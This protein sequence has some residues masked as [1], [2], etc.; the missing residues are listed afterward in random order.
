MGEV[1][2]L[3]GAWHKPRLVPCSWPAPCCQRFDSQ[4]IFNS[5]SHPPRPVICH[6]PSASPRLGRKK[7]LSWPPRLLLP[8]S[9]KRPVFRSL[10]TLPHHTSPPWFPPSEK[11]NFLRCGLGAARGGARAL[12]RGRG[13]R[14]SGGPGQE[15]EASPRLGPLPV[16]RRLRGR[17]YHHHHHSHR[18]PGRSR[19]HDAGRG[20]PG[21]SDPQSEPRRR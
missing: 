17:R 15:E 1:S 21:R 13:W 8:G 11:Q 18:R 19:P 9:G 20:S 4:V 16:S 12:A 14:G 2:Q 6:F 5:C 3:P 10:A 7:S